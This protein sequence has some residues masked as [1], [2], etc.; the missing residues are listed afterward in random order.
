M[1]TKFRYNNWVRLLKSKGLIT[2]P[3]EP[4]NWNSVKNS[5]RSVLIAL[6]NDSRNIHVVNHYLGNI[7]KA[8]KQKAISVLIPAD[9]ADFILEMRF[10][11][12]HIV[13]PPVKS[14]NF[15]VTEDMLPE[16][17]SEDFPVCI[18][19]NET[20]F[21]LSHYIIATRGKEMS[22]GFHNEFT[23]LLFTMT[24]KTSGRA[25]YDKG[26]Q[27]LLKLAGLELP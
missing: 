17:P 10:Y 25:S 14:L 27:S 18:D 26:F 4:L 1:L 7:L 15:P 22:L 16:M 3:D 20:P 21:I 6:P 12:N 23:D 19:L 2:L 9:Y 24:L 11:R 13:L 8:D 5:G